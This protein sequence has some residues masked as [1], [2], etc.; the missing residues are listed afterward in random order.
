VVKA[1]VAPQNKVERRRE[2]NQLPLPQSIEER[3]ND[4]RFKDFYK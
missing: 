1:P 3:K 2:S 4:P